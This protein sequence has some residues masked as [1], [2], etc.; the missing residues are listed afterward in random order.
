MFFNQI[1]GDNTAGATIAYD[2]AS[3]K[4]ASELGLRFDKPDHIW[5]FRFNDKGDAVGL[6]QFKP[7]KA[8]TTVVHSEM[9]LKDIPAG[10]V[11][12]LPLGVHFEVKY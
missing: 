8:V 1:S 6:L 9:N 2:F 3:K 4:Y 7:H 5:Q 11:N 10:K 12:K